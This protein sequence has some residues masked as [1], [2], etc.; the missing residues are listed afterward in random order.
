MR[1]CSAIYFSRVPEVNTAD[2]C[3]MRVKGARALYG[4]CFVGDLFPVKYFGFGSSRCFIS[5]KWARV[6]GVDDC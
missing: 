6:G 1:I 4:V 3:I 2:G 5:L